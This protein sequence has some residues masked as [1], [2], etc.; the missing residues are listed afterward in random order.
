VDHTHGKSD[1]GSNIK[2]RDAGKQNNFI[3]RP[4]A[5]HAPRA[6]T[7]DPKKMRSHLKN[8]S[9]TIEQHC[10]AVSSPHRQR[11]PTVQLM[12]AVSTL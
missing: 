7:H 12:V 5:Y 10:Q 2:G 8:R 4:C 11:H 9:L 6:H 1:V 3:F